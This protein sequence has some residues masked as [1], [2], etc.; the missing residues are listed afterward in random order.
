MQNVVQHRF[1]DRGLRH[2]LLDPR[3]ILMPANACSDGDDIFRPKN[4][5]RHA[6]VFDWLRIANRFY[7]QPRSSQELK[8]E[9]L[10]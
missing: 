5:R 10:K 2:E 1:V 4:F 8:R 7:G 3:Q 9:I 6:F